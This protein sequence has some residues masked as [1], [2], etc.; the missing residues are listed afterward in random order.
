MVYTLLTFGSGF[1]AGVA[2]HLK[3][4]APGQCLHANTDVNIVANNCLANEPKQTWTYNVSARQLVNANGKCLTAGSKNT[5]VSLSVCQSSKSRE[6]VYDST[7]QRYKNSQTNQ[8]LNVN[9]GALNGQARVINCGTASS[10]KWQFITVT[11]PP[12]P[13]VNWLQHDLKLNGIGVGV[14]S[15]NKALLVSLGDGFNSPTSYDATFT[16][17]LFDAGYSLVINGT[18]ITNRSSFHFNSI[19]YGSSIPLQRYLNGVLVDTYSLVFTNLPVIQLKAAEIVDEPKLPGTFRLMSAKFNQDTGVQNMG[20]EFRGNSAQDYPKKPYSIK[21]GTAADWAIGLDVKLLD[22]RKDSDWILDAAYRD[23]IVVRNIVS[24]DIFRALRPA[25]YTDQTGVGKGQSSMRGYLAEV[26]QNELYQGVYILEEKPDRK[27]YDL[28]K[29]TVPTD[30]NGV[31]QW[32]QVDFSNPENGSVLYKADNG[33]NVFYD[34]ATVPDNFEQAYPKPTDV[35]RWEPLIE[36]THFVATAS[37][38]AFI[39]GIGDRIDIDSVVDWWL[40]VDSSA[41]GDNIKKN[42]YMAKSGSGKFFMATWDHDASFG[43]DWEGALAV[44]AS[45]ESFLEWQYPENNLIRRLKELP[46]TGFNAKLKARWNALRPTVFNQANLVARFASYS[47]EASKG[48]AKNRNLAR[49]PGTGGA[50]AG[51]TRLGT[52]AFIKGILDS[53]LPLL[54]EV[55]NNL[56]EN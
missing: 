18:T 40:L 24:H 15:V 19:Q 43:M 12:P 10:Q 21:I 44:D 8:C 41:A 20:I 5:A 17:G 45:A 53:R 48:G 32:S 46:A 13:A 28:K 30:A 34:A 52:V 29:I 25:A 23:Q 26:I 9:N 2:D 11:P 55:I 14:E 42:F 33:D 7:T 1:A 51:D 22:M 37:D 16:Y 27:L 6:W 47:A 38:Q 39:A 56:P 35:V 36:F 31:A 49:W 50:G 54:D 4:A 3:N